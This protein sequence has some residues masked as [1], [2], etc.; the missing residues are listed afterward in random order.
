MLIT[1]S[2]IKMGLDMLI[3]SLPPGTVEQVIHLLQTVNNKVVTTS[4]DI[5]NI[6]SDIAEIKQ[7]LA[8]KD[9]DNGNGNRKRLPSPRGSA[10]S[11]T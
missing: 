4:N 10:G 7:L 6:K 11:G 1:E 8:S 2:M 5:E 3:K 9:N